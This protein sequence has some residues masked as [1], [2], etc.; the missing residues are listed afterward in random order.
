MEHTEE[1]NVII[2]PSPT[3][4]DPQGPVEEPKKRKARVKKT[5][6]PSDELYSQLIQS[7]TELRDLTRKITVLVKDAQK[8]SKKEIKSANNLVRKGKTGGKAKG[9]ACPA[10]ISNE[11]INY[12]LN[13]ANITSID[14]IMPDQTIVPVPI[15][16][17]CLLAR[18][19]LTAALCEHFRLSNMRK[20]L[21][22]KRDIYLDP[23]TTKLFNIDIKQF[24]EDGGRVSQ[25]GEPIITYFNLQRYLPQHCG[26]L[27]EGH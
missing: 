5:Y 1:V 16:T 8:V 23:A 24:T 14:R 13:E 17:G 7:M 4:V 27:S 3:P 25:D 18:N 12:L 19:E 10:P 22:D 21:S 9:F 6:P 26:K 15:E 11:M 2:V 20:N